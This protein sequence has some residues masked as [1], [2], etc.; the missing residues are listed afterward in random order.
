MET[1]RDAAL[2]W[3]GE[4]PSRKDKVQWFVENWQRMPGLRD[5]VNKF[6]VTVK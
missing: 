2:A 3:C 4:K 1:V 5:Y 6:K